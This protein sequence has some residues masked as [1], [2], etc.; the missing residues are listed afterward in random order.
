MEWNEDAKRWDA[1]HHPFTSPVK[2][3]I[4]FQIQDYGIGISNDPS[5]NIGASKYSKAFSAI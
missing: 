2:D 5:L 3:D 4:E 1:L